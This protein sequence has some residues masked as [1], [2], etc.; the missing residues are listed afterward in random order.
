TLAPVDEAY[1]GIVVIHD[2][3]AFDDHTTRAYLEAEMDL[4]RRQHPDLDSEMVVDARHVEI[5]VR[6]Y[7]VSEVGGLGRRTQGFVHAGEVDRGPLPPLRVTEEDLYRVRAAGLGLGDGIA[8]F[9]VG[10]DSLLDHGSD[11]I[12]CS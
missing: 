9:D 4:L 5:E 12:A 11:G 10:T 8:L 3:N 2:M 7:V 1:L 6:V